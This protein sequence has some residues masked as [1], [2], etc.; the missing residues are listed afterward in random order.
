MIERL[1]LRVRHAARVAWFK[2]GGK[3]VPSR[4]YCVACRCRWLMHEDGMMQMGQG[5]L[6]CRHCDN[7]KLP[8]LRWEMYL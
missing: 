2:L 6:P 3:F 5:H 4:F 1:W 8:P 7:A